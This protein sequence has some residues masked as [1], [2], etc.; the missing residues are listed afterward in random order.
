MAV[1]PLA[2]MLSMSVSRSPRACSSSVRTGRKFFTDEP[3]S[4]SPTASLSPWICSTKA[5]SASWVLRSSLPLHAARG[6]DHQIDIGRLLGVVPDVAHHID[7]RRR[8]H[9]QRG[10]RLAPVDAGRPGKRAGRP[11]ERY[12]QV[13]GSVAGGQQFL[14]RGRVGQKIGEGLEGLPLIGGDGVVV[15]PPVRFAQFEQRQRMV[16][17]ERALGRV[18]GD[19]RVAPDCAGSSR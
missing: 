2:S 3:N 14:L 8:G 10:L 4:T 9:L 1:L 12:A 19:Q 6:V 16:G 7:D 17:P 13:G 15:A 11:V 18:D 5:V